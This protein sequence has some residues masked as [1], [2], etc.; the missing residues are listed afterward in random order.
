MKIGSNKIVEVKLTN[1]KIKTNQ[2]DEI[3]HS[4]CMLTYKIY[5]TCVGAFLCEEK[6]LHFDF[7]EFD[8]G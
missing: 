5:Y 2:N 3:H 7:C 6:R 8:L 1:N 4:T